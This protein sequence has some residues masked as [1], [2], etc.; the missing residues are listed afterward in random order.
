[1]RH[2]KKN[3]ETELPDDLYVT[4]G[5]RVSK[6]FKEET[7]KASNTARMNLSEYIREAVRHFNHL[8][9]VSSINDNKF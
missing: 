5:A 8:H 2:F 3:R 4:I 6:I 9:N 7:V 1:M